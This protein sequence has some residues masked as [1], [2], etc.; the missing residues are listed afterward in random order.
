MQIPSKA[1]PVGQLFQIGSII[2][3]S[4]AG[5][6]GL[7]G[8][9]S[10]EAKS[11][12]SAV[13]AEFGYTLDLV[14][15]LEGGVETGTVDLH[16]LDAAIEADLEQLFSLEGLTAFGYAHYTNGKS[17]SGLVGDAQGINNIE[18]G[19]EALRLQEFWLRKEFGTSDVSALL[20]LYDINSEFDGLSSTDFFIHG[21]HGI[22][23]DIAQSGENGPSIFPVT[24]L[25][26]KAEAE[27]ENGFRLRAAIADGVPGDPEHPRRTTIDLSAD[28]G[29][30]LIGEL[31]HQTS[32]RRVIGGV[33]GYTSRFDRLD[34]GQGRGN[35]G[36]Y[37]GGEFAL[38][39]SQL[40]DPDAPVWFTRIGVAEA[41]FNPFEWY[42]SSGIVWSSL[43]INTRFGI[44]VAHAITSDSYRGE[45]P[46]AEQSETNIEA[47][48]AVPVLENLSVQPYAQLVLNPGADPTLENA[49][50]A[51]LRL[52]TSVSFHP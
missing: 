13:A 42:V 51:G 37:L 5:A 48:A 40:D 2:R 19:V 44:A 22:G 38:G 14:S 39:D 10:I 29:A 23:T 7:I 47:S 33:W 32:Q 52:S 43:Q 15:N 27:L 9:L 46:G 28:D 1:S 36:A 11:E 50:I 16:Y 4:V 31:E 12:E 18:S 41:E 45:W 3:Q 17:I 34:G 21:A 35:T 6:V 26:L 20:G 30:F 25:T 24:S 49:I 8:A